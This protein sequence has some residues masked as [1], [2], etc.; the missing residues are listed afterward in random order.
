MTR[1]RETAAESLESD[2]PVLA[3]LVPSATGFQLRATPDV[4]EADGAGRIYRTPDGR[5]TLDWQTA[6]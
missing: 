3:L 2:V 4:R 1:N 6:S 5:I